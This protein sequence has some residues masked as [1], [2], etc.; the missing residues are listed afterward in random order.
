MADNKHRGLVQIYTGDGKGKTTASLGLALRA[1]GQGMKVIMIQFLKG[2]PG[3]EHYFNEKYGAFEIRQFSK[4]NIFAKKDEQLKEEALQAFRFAEETIK[5]GQY[6]IVI[7]DEIFI[8][9]WRNFISLEQILSLMDERP[10]HMELVMSGRKAPQEI[11][12]KADLVSEI[13]MIKHPFNDGV[14]QRRGIEY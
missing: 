2:D 5:N 7:L 1:A 9:H 6:D 10:P 4:G 14:K 8:A 13:L 12:K 11:I 3:G